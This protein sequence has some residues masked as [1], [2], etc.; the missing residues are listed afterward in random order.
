MSVTNTTTLNDLLPQITA[1]ALYVASEKSIMRGLVRNYTLSPGQGK[2]V[3]VPIYPKQTAASL[4]EATASNQ[5]QVSTDG[6][7][8]TVSEV[9]LYAT[10]SDLAL[11]ASNSNVVA[12]LGRLFGEAIARKIDT[13]LMSLFMGFGTNQVGGVSTTAT[14]ALLFQAIAKL[15]SQGYDTSNDCAIVL[16]PNVA[17]DVA[18]TLTST[19]AAPASAIGNSALENGFMGM[20]GG[21]PVYQSSLVPLETGS[22]AAGDYA[23]GIFHKDALGLAMMKDITIETQ[24]Q[25]A[26]RGYDIVGSAIYGVGELYDNAGVRG[27]FDSSIE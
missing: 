15:R 21:V 20:L 5:V 7:T 27:I 12:D 26:A 19:F 10:V 17:Y 6:A 2:T 24:R 3:T 8:L 14:P 9:G 11:M 13:D 23:C 4:T 22:G 16:H 25:A 18:S 1:E